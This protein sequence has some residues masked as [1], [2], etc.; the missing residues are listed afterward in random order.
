MP[1]ISNKVAKT[2]E[3]VYLKLPD[4]EGVRFSLYKEVE[5]REAQPGDDL[6]FFRKINVDGVEK[7]IKYVIHLRDIT[8][9][10]IK[11]W[12]VGSAS[13]INQLINI[14]AEV[15]D[16][17]EIEK[18]KTGERPQDIRYRIKMVKK[19]SPKT[20]TAADDEPD[21]DDGEPPF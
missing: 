15:D 19:S 6:K 8:T 4:N 20:G 18:I 12:Q 7:F 17:V 10:D 1:L 5:M 2:A 16:V 9:G 3:G 11:E 21:M 14:K 13:A